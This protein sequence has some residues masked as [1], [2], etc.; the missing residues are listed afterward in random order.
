MATFTPGQL[1]TQ[2]VEIQVEYCGICHSDLTMLDNK[3]GL[4]QYPFVPGHE[5][6]GTVAAVGDAVTKVRVGQRV[7][8]GWF[9]R[10]CLQCNCCVSGDDHLCLTGEGMIVGRY[11][12]F[13]QKV[14]AHQNWAIPL[15]AALD[16]ATAGPLLC[17]GIT[18]FNPLVQFDV[19]PT[20]RVGVIGIGGLGHLALQFLRAWGCDVTAFSSNPDKEVEA[21][22]MGANHFIDSRDPQALKAVANSFDL[23]I[24][25]VDADLDWDTYIAALRPKG[26]LHLV[27]VVPKVSFQSLPFILGQKS[28]SASPVGSSATISRMLDFAAQHRIE[29]ITELFS[30]DQVNEAIAKLRNG[31]PRYRLV[32]KH[33]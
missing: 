21:R 26:R 19:K 9:S 29:A 20:D 4:T 22:Q 8:L 11:G 23:I 25:T 12:G 1:K 13:A 5:V 7:G 10:S 33:T 15:P 14:R 3:W 31:K 2:E 32:L 17:G 24:S 27:G 18:V 28:I 6:I 30:F 16:P